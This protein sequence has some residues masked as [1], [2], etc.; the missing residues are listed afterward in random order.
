MPLCCSSILGTN[1]GG[2]S[3]IFHFQVKS[4]TV[5]NVVYTND[6]V[7]FLISSRRKVGDTIHVSWLAGL[8]TRRLPWVETVGSLGSENVF[9]GLVKMSYV[10]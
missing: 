6:I 9:W 1:E 2:I 5:Y 4:V 7:L 8:S 10:W 3:L